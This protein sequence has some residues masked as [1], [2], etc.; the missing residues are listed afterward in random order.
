MINVVSSFLF[1]LLFY[2]TCHSEPKI[3][4]GGNDFNVFP[5]V[6]PKGEGIAR[7]KYWSHP[8]MSWDEAQ[9]WVGYN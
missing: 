6:D 3:I 9:L 7:I 1:L 2:F 4:V 5:H 8:N